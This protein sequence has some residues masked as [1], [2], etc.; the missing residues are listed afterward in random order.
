MVASNK[1]L[2]SVSFKEIE[3]KTVDN[4]NINSNELRSLDG[5]SHNFK[6]TVEHNSDRIVFEKYAEL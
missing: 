1:T 3:E 5:F 4:L 6:L 2:K